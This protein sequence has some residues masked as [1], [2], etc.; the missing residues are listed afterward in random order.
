MFS[1]CREDSVDSNKSIFRYNEPKSVT[2]LDP[3]FARNMA[4][5]WVVNMLFNGLV[6][7]DSDLIV[8]PCI[9]SRWNISEDGLSYHFWLRKDVQFHPDQAIKQGRTVTAHDFVY[10]FNRIL[11]PETASPGRWVFA[12]VDTL[13]GKGFSALNDSELVI[14]LRKSYPPFLGILS[15]PYCSVVPRE[16]VEKYQNTYRTHPVGTGPFQYFIWKE[17]IKLVLHKNENYFEKD[18]S[19]QKLPYIDAVSVTFVSDA[20]SSFMS[21]LKGQTDFLNGL[22]DGSYKDAILTRKGELKPDLQSKFYMLRSP[23]LNTEYLG[24][25]VSD[26][27]TAVRNSV[28]LNVN[29]RQAVNYAIDRKKMLK[30]IRNGVGFPGEG[31]IVPQ[32]LMTANPLDSVQKPQ[33]GYTYNPAK[34]KELLEK[35]G[36]FKKYNEPEVKLYTTAQYAD[37]SEYIQKQLNEL[38]IKVSLELNPPGTHGELV[39][40]C[41]APFFRKSWV[42]DYPDPE[43]YLSLLYSENFTP[44][45]PNYTLYNNPKFDQLYKLAMQNNSHPERLAIYRKMDSLAAS[46]AP[47]VVLF[48]DES[49]RFV[50]K[51][52]KGLGT[53]AMNLLDLKR[54]K[55]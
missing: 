55:K 40:K 23:F 38:G 39:A 28:V 4:N 22:D 35:S 6:Q 19:N 51:R 43:N 24:F 9:A 54:V 13:K 12:M 8:Q 49:L 25:I 7:L 26:T 41:Q 37:L 11:S 42:A 27:A 46:D 36:Y 44:N 21:F 5:T 14:K 31:G 10:S 48:Y 47:V 45:G 15:M 18:N 17:G 30:Y 50:N 32:I 16:A 52:I 1:A 53:N 3:A 29:F 2:S 34:A 33:Y 20:Q